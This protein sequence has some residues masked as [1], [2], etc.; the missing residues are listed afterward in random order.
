MKTIDRYVLAVAE[1]LPED[2]REDIKNELYTNIEDM[3]PENPLEDDIRIVLEK[4]GDP[5]KLANEYRGTKRYLIGPDM[6]DSYISVLKLV[7]G[8]VAIV[9]VIVSLLKAAVNP[10][11]SEGLIG[12]SIDI[13][14]NTIGAVIEG[15][16]QGFMWVTLVFVILERTGVN[17]G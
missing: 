5:V 17:E 6:Y 3:L 11:A 15:A 2:I 8:I 13:L 12:M 4:L 14:A 16:I 1:R 10:P 7:T 9:F